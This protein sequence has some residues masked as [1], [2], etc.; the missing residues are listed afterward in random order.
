M[1]ASPLHTPLAFHA[2]HAFHAFRIFRIFRVFR[3]FP[4][5]IW[6]LTHGYS[7]ILWV[8]LQRVSPL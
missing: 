1:G 3:V 7:A 2:F 5:D 8:G 6:H 4:E